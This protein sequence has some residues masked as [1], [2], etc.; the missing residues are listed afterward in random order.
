M[1]LIP[2]RSIEYIKTQEELDAYTQAVREL[3]RE[4]CAKL[5]EARAAEEV[6]MAYAGIALDCAEDIR[7]SEPA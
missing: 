3:E 6:G 7:A 1:E 2:F 4:R 5:C